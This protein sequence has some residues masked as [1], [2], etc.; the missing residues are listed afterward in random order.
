MASS[1]Y[2]AVKMP[3]NLPVFRP[4]RAICDTLRHA[5]TCAYE[6]TETNLFYNASHTQELGTDTEIQ[7]KNC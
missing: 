1:K 4:L 6:L 2:A 3:Y 7:R 5:I